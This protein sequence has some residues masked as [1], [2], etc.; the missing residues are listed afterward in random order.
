MK[1]KPNFNFALIEIEKFSKVFKAFEEVKNTINT[2][3]SFEQNVKE[4]EQ[5]RNSAELQT[6]EAHNT[7]EAFRKKVGEE[8][9]RLSKENQI[10]FEQQKEKNNLSLLK[11]TQEFQKLKQEQE[12]ELS[13]IADNIEVFKQTNNSLVK[14]ITQKQKELTVLESR[15]IET[16]KQIA[17]LLKE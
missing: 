15:L 14:E 7:L 8:K 10:S 13:L 3:A 9:D 6:K 17:I 11:M 2:L 5:S 16:R 1:E 4:L 12:E